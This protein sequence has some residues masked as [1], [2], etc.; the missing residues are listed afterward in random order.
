MTDLVDPLEESQFLLSL[1]L[2]QVAK[3]GPFQ[4]GA[5]RNIL[6][7]KTLTGGTLLSDLAETG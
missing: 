4:A 3:T 7:G 6:L 2:S 1:L 5:T